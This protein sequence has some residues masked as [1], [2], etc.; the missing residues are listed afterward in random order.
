MSQPPAEPSADAATGTVPDAPAA[1]DAS[2]A[3]R[4]ATPAESKALAHP[5]RLR[6][7]R[8]CGLEPLTNRQLAERLEADPATVLYHVRRLVDA[9]FLRALPARTGAHG[10]R[11]KPYESTGLSWRLEN[12]L[13]DMP[14][15]LAAPLEA[16]L[17]ELESAGH[18]SIVQFGRVALHLSDA[19][20]AELGR[21]IDELLDE[22][23]SGD[24]ARRGEPA[25]GGVVVF[26]RMAAPP[27][28]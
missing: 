13:R 4:P 12:P 11:E 24:S 28:E 16:F 15:G 21:R 14:G 17:G 25:Y 1:R 27:A 8:L 19:Q 26:H 18:D 22:Y 10:S 9:G 3:R 7:I 20:L 5:L 23:V 2:F 6:I